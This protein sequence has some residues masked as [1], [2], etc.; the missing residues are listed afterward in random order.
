M[1]YMEFS[2]VLGTQYLIKNLTNSSHIESKKHEQKQKP[3]IHKR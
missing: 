3:G 2:S 1:T